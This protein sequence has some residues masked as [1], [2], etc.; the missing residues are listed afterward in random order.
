MTVRTKKKTTKKKVAAVIEKIIALPTDKELIDERLILVFGE[1][2]VDILK[3]GGVIVRFPTI[4]IVNNSGR[5]QDITDLFIRLKWDYNLNDK[6]VRFN[7]TIDGVRTSFSDEELYS[8]YIHSH[9]RK[10]KLGCSDNNYGRDRSGYPTDRDTTAI[11]GWEDFCLG[12]DTLGQTLSGLH[13]EFE[14]DKFY[15]LLNTIDEFVRWE[16]EEG[17][18][19]IRM[20]KIK[21][22]DNSYHE[23]PEEAIIEFADEKIVKFFYKE[24]AKWTDLSTFDYFVDGDNID[25]L[26]EDKVKIAVEEILLELDSTYTFILGIPK[27]T[28]YKDAYYQKHLGEVDILDF[29]KQV[30]FEGSITFKGEILK[31]TVTSSASD[32]TEL[33]KEIDKE[34]ELVPHPYIVKT[35]LNKFKYQLLK[36]LKKKDTWE[37]IK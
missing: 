21:R 4:T 29:I 35:V 10:L 22:V 9:L 32:R 34:G 2:N 17:G 11:I 25:Y 23:V 26:F 36:N 19:H 14:I 8:C 27:L 16:S 24:I 6:V 18:P 12:G 31:P 33:T 15:I 30:K 37:L 20:S 3:Q 1:E 7:N 13:M 5:Q 28:K